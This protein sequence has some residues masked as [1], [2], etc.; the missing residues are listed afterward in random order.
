VMD[1][2]VVFHRCVDQTQLVCG[3]SGANAAEGVNRNETS[4]RRSA[5]AVLGTQLLQQRLK[6]ER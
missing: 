1:S 3:R 4:V 5:V 6:P 2:M